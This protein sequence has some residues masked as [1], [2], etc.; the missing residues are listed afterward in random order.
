VLFLGAGASKAVELPDLYDLTKKIRRE[1]DDPFEE[2]ERVLKQPK[3]RIKYPH[4]ELDLEIFLT[5]LDSL[6]DPLN[7]IPELS[8][9]ATYLYKLLENK[10][11]IDKI[12]IQKERARDLKEKSV[13]LTSDILDT[14][15]REKAKSLYD[16]LFSIGDLNGEIKNAIGQ[17]VHNIFNYIATTNYDLVIESCVKGHPTNSIYLT[18]R[19]FKTIEGETTQYLDLPWLRENASMVHYLNLHGSLDWWKR[20]DGK[21][22]ISSGKPLYGEKLI[23]HIMIYP[24]Y[25]KYVSREP[26]YSLYTAFRKNLFKEEIVIVI[27]YSFRDISIN[28][29]LV[30]HLQTTEK[31]RLIVSA[32]STSAKQRINKIFGQSKRISIIKNYFGEDVFIKK[33]KNE[34]R[35]Q[36]IKII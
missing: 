5:I 30:D 18:H 36:A 34:L 2:I 31:S 21:I 27:G 17:T 23:D 33:L 15:N 19:G 16:K 9:F 13:K 35:H 12:K 22:I 6:A 14:F 32:R 3:G 20:D 11:A 4:K 10:K 28:N 7:A 1:T 26:F 8:P 24:I 29:A 25:E